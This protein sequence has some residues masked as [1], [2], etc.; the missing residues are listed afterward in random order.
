VTVHGM[1]HEVS[2]EIGSDRETL[3]ALV[4]DLE[5][6]GEWS[7]ENA[8]GEWQDG[9]SGAV[10]DRFVGLNRVGEYEWSVSCEVTR[11]DR[12]EVF[13]WV[14]GPDVGPLAR[15]T[16]RFA[17]SGANTIVTE[18][19]DVEKLPASLES[20]TPEQ[21]TKRVATV[22]AGML[23]TLESLKAFAEG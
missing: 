21:L 6:M 17:E 9:G 8:G 19:W 11:A 20:R 4:S 5:R 12:G 1:Q 15:W 7:P 3:Y 13:E 22:Q 23:S 2:I 16:Y 10:G 14:T 18:T